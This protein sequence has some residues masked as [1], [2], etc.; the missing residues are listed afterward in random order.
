MKVS[1]SSWHYWIYKNS[2]EHGCAFEPNNLCPYFWR[3]VGG[4]IKI[5]V[6]TAVVAI[7]L[8]FVGWLFYA[9]TGATFVS[10]A[11][12]GV[13]IAVSVNWDEIRWA[14]EER[15]GKSEEVET[16]EPGLLRS[17]LKAKKDKVCPVIEMVE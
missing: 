4:G 12:I 16:P 17:W 9:H 11:V 10:T 3:V 7:V 6:V 15:F 5:L 14:Y 2:F 13:I 8:G 1:K